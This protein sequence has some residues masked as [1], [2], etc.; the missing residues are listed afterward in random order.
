[1]SKRFLLIIVAVVISLVIT[2]CWVNNAN[3][4]DKNDDDTTENL[5]E[6]EYEL[7]EEGIIE[8]NNAQKVIE[9]IS[10]KLIDAISDKDMETISKF[11]HPTKGLRFTPYTSVSLKDDIVFN[12]VEVEEFFNNKNVYLW[13]YYDGI[14][15]EILLT[16]GEYYE[17]FIYT[18]DFKNIEDV[19]YNE[20]LSGGNAVENQFEVYENPI[21]VEYYFPG[22][23]PE[24]GA[25]D[26]E[27]LRL[28]FEQY[29][30]EWKLVGIIHNQWTI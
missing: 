4:R 14:G 21:I 20:V 9:Q 1:M 18:K 27:S 12:K 5:I 22:L 16:P 2:G 15:D 7:N 29:G 30:N 17:E 26:W 19:G 10:S 3:E 24:D 13:G 28:V 8:P 25:M 23:F 11:V 6:N